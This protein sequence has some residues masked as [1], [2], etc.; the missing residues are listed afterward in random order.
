MLSE[1]RLIQNYE[2]YVDLLLQTGDDR[3]DQLQKMIDYFGDRLVLCPASYRK[4]LNSCFPGGFIEHSLQVMKTCSRL[5]KVAPD[6][7]GSIPE[8]SIVFTSLLHDV[9]KL[10]V[11]D[12]D[13]YVPQTNNYYRERGNLYEFNQNMPQCTISHASI[14]TLQYFGI[15]M[16][17]Q[18]YQ[19]IMLVDS[20]ESEDSK[21]YNM[22]ESSLTLLLKQADR[23]SC[24]QERITQQQQ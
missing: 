10:G 9:G 7:Y 19:A 21:Y 24:E 8:S 18:E 16:D 23:L 4:N 13:R 17:F 5:R 22:H 14:F 1:E 6:V 11:L 20:T 3:R 12:Q 2:K 15:R